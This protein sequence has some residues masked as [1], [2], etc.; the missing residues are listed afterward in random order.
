M[1]TNEE[2]MNEIVMG[3]VNEITELKA[4]IAGIEIRLYNY[5]KMKI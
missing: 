5:E 3:Q 2:I 4:K 1:K